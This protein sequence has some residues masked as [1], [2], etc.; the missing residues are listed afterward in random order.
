MPQIDTYFKDIGVGSGS[1]RAKF[2]SDGTLKFEGDSTTW[3][4]IVGSLIGK[5]L[6][7]TVGKVDYNWAEN[8]I[9]FQSGG[10][11]STA[12]DIVNINLQYPHAAKEGGIFAF[13][14]HYEQTD[15]Y[16]NMPVQFTVK[17]RVQNNGAAKNTTWTTVTVE[18]NDDNTVFP[19]SSGTLNQ[20][21][22]LVDIDITG[23]NI[24]STVQIQFARTDSATGDLYATFAD[25]HI[26][27]DT[28]GSRSQYSK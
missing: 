21:L 17:Y 26:E 4:D 23:M 8:S 2:E 13:H 10:S 3:D 25:A 22:K 15:T 14:L 5:K 1:D 6:S 16:A 20:I 18:A 12:N 11:I 9:K 27:R 28:I 7:S 19:Y 24:S